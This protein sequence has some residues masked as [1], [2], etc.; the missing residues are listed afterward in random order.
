MD[1]D[2]D[3]DSVDDRR[4]FRPLTVEVRGAVSCIFLAPRQECLI[5]RKPRTMYPRG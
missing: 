1:D 4:N 3:M 5:R 2:V